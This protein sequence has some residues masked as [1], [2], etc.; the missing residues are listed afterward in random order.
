MRRLMQ[1]A[2]LRIAVPAGLIVALL[3]VPYVLV[4]SVHP[5][6]R[7]LRL[8][9]LFPVTVLLAQISVAWTPLSGG[10]ERFLRPLGLPSW[11]CLILVGLGLAVGKELCLRPLLLR[12]AADWPSPASWG[13]LLVW[14]P[15][16]ALFQPLV[17]VA[18]CYAFAARLLH[19]RAAAPAAVVLAYQAVHVWQ[20]GGGTPAWAVVL[21]VLLSGVY[22][23]ALALS[24][25]RFGFAGPAVIVLVC[26]WRHAVLLLSS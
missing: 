22:G 13:M 10:S 1:P 23:L 19:W 8:V 9:F 12:L 21:L 18:G 14:L 7:T 20:F 5:E 11:G 15:W 24:Y 3:C 16:V 2:T 17:F 4:R 25:R 6:L 26:Q